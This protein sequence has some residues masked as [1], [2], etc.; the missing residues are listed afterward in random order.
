MK[1]KNPKSKKSDEGFVHIVLEEL[2]NVS[3]PEQYDDAGN[4][5][6]IPDSIIATECF[7]EAYGNNGITL[8]AIVKTS[9]IRL[10][11]FLAWLYVFSDPNK[12][13]II[14]PAF[15][16]DTNDDSRIL[17]YDIIDGNNYFAVNNN[18]YAAVATDKGNLAIKLVHSLLY[19]CDALTVHTG[20][21]DAPDIIYPV[22]L[23]DK[24]DGRFLLTC[25]VRLDDETKWYTPVCM[26][27]EEIIDKI[28]L[29]Q[30]IE[31]LVHIDE[32]AIIDNALYRLVIDECGQ[33]FVKSFEQVT[34]EIREA[35][36]LKL[37]ESL[38]IPESKPVFKLKLNQKQFGKQVIN[39]KPV[40][41]PLIR[42]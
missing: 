5:C 6:L 29:E 21:S 31:Y 27:E 40:I 13:P 30:T 26:A 3:E 34:P 24:S 33:H 18:L 38:P 7:K 14:A 35:E 2:G 41:V 11:S 25:W 23:Y 19:A 9:S 10:P 36:N 39:E 20:D 8:L 32:K 15:E 42:N 1:K 37:D 22:K 4:E 17:S 28:D 12:L 16:I